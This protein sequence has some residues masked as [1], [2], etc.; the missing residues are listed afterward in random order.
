M[1]ERCTAVRDALEDPPGPA[2]LSRQA[3]LSMCLAARASALLRMGRVAEAVED[4]RRAV[5]VA[6]EAGGGA[7]EAMALGSLSLAIAQDGD[8]DGAL[9]LARR[10]QGSLR[11]TRACCGEASAGSSPGS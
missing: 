3:L 9:R 2:A 7:I 1:L 8:V 5:R 10:A 4:G 11:A 6:G